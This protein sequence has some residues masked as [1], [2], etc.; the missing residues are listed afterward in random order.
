LGT[1]LLERR[2]TGAVLTDAGRESMNFAIRTISDFEA[3][4]S[5]FG[6]VPTVL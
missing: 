3:L 6:H 2:G 4:V 1:R 5:R